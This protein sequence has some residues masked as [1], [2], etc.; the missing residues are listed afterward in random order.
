MP[1]NREEFIRELLTFIDPDLDYDSWLAVG[2]AIK[3]EGL[4]ID[5]WDEWSRKGRKYKPGCCEAHWD[6][7]KSTGITGA[8]I[9]H[10]AKEGGWA[11]KPRDDSGWEPISME[12]AV[13]PGEWVPRRDPLKPLTDDPAQQM[14]RFLQTAF[15]DGDQ[16]NIVAASKFDETRGKWVPANRG[17]TYRL[18]YIL[19]TLKTG[20]IDSLI[21][22]RSREAGVWVR[23]NPMDG[24]GVK[25]ENV[26]DFRHVLVES[27]SV[28]LERQIEV[29]RELELPIATL[30]TSG[31]KSVHALVKINAPDLDTYRRRVQAVFKACRDSGLDIDEQNKN[32]ARLCRLAGVERGDKLQSLLA[33]DIGCRSFEEW[34][35]NLQIDA[36]P[37]FDSL[38][39]WFDNPPQ[40]PPE[41]IRGIL[42]KGE[43]LVL[44]GP[45][46]AGKSFALIQ[47]AIA[48]ATGGWWMGRIKCE[49]QRVIYINFELTKANAANRIIDTW[50]AVRSGTEGIQNLSVWNLRGQVVS[51]KTIV[52]TIIRRHKASANPADLY[53]FDPIYKLNL[54]DE[55]AAKDTNELMREFDRLCT[56]TG[57]NMAYAHHHAKGSQFGKRALDRGSGSGVI[58]RDADAAIDLDFLWVPEKIRRE[59]AAYYKDDSWMK[60]TALRVEM[61]LRNFESKPPFNVWF[62]YPKH[63]YDGSKEFQA[64]RGEAEKDNFARAEDGKQ[65]KKEETDSRIK[66]ALEAAIEADG[67]AQIGDIESSTGLSRKRIRQYLDTSEGY[68]KDKN[69]KISRVGL[70]GKSQSQVDD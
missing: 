2:M 61:T 56:Q 17:F 62:R 12:D 15:Q 33:V 45:S 31:S 3:D 53:I 68:E 60:A 50:K 14:I 48:C 52:D 36:L 6:T 64:L 8:S 9:T 66:E 22:E 41:T 40:L 57:A 46:K 54:G 4:E 30:T 11:P 28:D 18:D 23:C 63:E 69:G 51:A 59:K 21:G 39:D 29:F 55:N 5:V 65:K 7:F 49:P 47:L 13:Q 10:L 1:E 67:F 42:R 37:E 20:G 43:K 34:E 19:K 70:S 58:G 24:H 44:T 16:V 25:N 35:E 27:D 32:P 26:T 38:S